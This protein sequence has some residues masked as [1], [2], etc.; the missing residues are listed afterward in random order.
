MKE[1]RDGGICLEGYETMRS[2]DRDAMIDYYI[3]NPDWCLERGFPDMQTLVDNFS[4][5]EDKGVF[6]NKQFNGEVL[7][8]LQ[9]YIFH[10]CSGH[11]RVR[12]NT[13][14]KLIPMLYFANGCDMVIECDDNISV[15][16]Y[17]FGE[18]D[19]SG[20]NSRAFKFFKRP[21]FALKDA[22]R[23]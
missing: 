20:N 2:C 13:E 4:D 19:V 5:I 15:P 12:L 9:T 7:D 11:I 23:R 10:N 22:P 8:E 1:A 16:L 6:I 21:I 18:N 14:K 17:I 3:T